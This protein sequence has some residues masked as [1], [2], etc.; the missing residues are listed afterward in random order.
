MMQRKEELNRFLHQVDKIFQE[1]SSVSIYAPEVSKAFD[2][3]AL[4]AVGLNDFKTVTM[5]EEK[6]PEFREYIF[7]EYRSYKDIYYKEKRKL[8]KYKKRYQR[9]LITS[10]LLMITTIASYAMLWSNM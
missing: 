7:N 6:Y 9:L 10:I 2:A 1:N 5:L 3:V 4:T 8:K